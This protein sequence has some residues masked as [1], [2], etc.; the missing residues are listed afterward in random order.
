MNPNQFYN[1]Q[2]K[3]TEKIK[4][5]ISEMY[6]NANK[7][8][9]IMLPGMLQLRLYTLF[10]I[11]GKF[12]EKELKLMID[13]ANGLLLD[14]QMMPNKDAFYYGI[15]DAIELDRLD[16]KWE[17]DKEIMEIMMEGFVPTNPKFEYE[18]SPRFWELQKKKLGF[19]HRYQQFSTDNKLAEYERQKKELEGQLESAETKIKELENDEVNNG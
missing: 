15:K 13:R 16:S 5:E 14:P 6:G 17:V 12:T 2:V 1:A 9:N 11:K 18:K 10:E 4:N 19:N 7:A 8:A 3:L